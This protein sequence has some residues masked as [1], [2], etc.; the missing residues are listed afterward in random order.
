[1]LSNKRDLPEMVAIVIDKNGTPESFRLKPQGR[2]IL[3]KYPRQYER[4]KHVEWIRRGALTLHDMR[5]GD[6][7]EIQ[8]GKRREM[9][10][11]Q[12]SPLPALVLGLL[13]LLFIY[14]FILCK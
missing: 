3:R 13:S 10:I 5:L 8:A 14:R 2:T 6:K 1:M 4:A 12:E 11:E 7:K 9:D